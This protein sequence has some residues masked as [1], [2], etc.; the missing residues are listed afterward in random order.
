MKRLIVLLFVVI[1]SSTIGFT[2]NSQT[3]NSTGSVVEVLYFHG[4]IRCNGCKAVGKYSKEVVDK[5]FA[6]QQRIGKVRFRDVDYSTEDG[7]KVAV[8]YHISFSGLVLAKKNNGKE[9]YED[10]SRFALMTAGSDSQKFK[11]ELT[12]KINTMLR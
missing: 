8:K 11:E 1:L 3:K 10:I 7:E 9:T 12:A 5:N 6:S 4:K 2:V